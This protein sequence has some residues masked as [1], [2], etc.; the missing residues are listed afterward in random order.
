MTEV[1]IHDYHLMLLPKML[2]DRFPEISIGYFQ[3]IPFPSFEVFRLLPWRIEILEGLLGADLI[4]FHTYDYERHFISS[5]RRLMGLDTYFNQVRYKK[6][7]LKVDNFPMGIDYEKFSSR[8]LEI[9]GEDARKIKKIPS[10]DRE[11]Y[12]GQ[13]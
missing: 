7:V 1:W 13:T 3:H 4:G 10:R 11:A 12:P 8:A 9:T 5:L 2:R 6:R